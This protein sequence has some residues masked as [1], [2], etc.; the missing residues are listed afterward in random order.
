[1]D[2]ASGSTSGVA[3]IFTGATR[4]VDLWRERTG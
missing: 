1:M 2:D 3:T 4:R